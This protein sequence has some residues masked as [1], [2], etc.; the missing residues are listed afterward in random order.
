VAHI[1]QEDLLIDRL[2]WLQ[3]S[4]FHFKGSGDCFSQKVACEAL[5]KDAAARRS[6][7]AHSH[8]S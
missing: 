8:S 5:L 4:D 6:S 2:S 7:A 1:S 3:V